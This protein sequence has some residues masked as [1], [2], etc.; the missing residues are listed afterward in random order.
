MKI[1]WKSAITSAALSVLFVLVY[2]S[3]NW[4]TSLRS[5]IGSCYF[6]WERHIP[7]VPALILPYMSIDLFF[8]AAPFLVRSDRELSTLARRITAAILISGLCFLL[9]PLKFAFERP[10]LD[11]FLGV[12]FNNFRTMDL[13]YNEFPSLH[14]SLWAILLDHYRRHTKGLLWI[15]VAVWFTLISI[16]PLFTYQHHVVDI[17]GGLALA[18][19]CFHFFRDQLLCQ[20]FTPNR[21]VAFYYA[22]ACLLLTAASFT[23]APWTY[24]L[25]WPAFSL[26]L[27]VAAYAFIGP[28]LYRKEQGR[29]PWTTWL[30][31]W[32]IL[33]GQR[34]S[35]IFYSRQC[36]PYDRLTDHLWIGR[37]LSTREARQA[38]TSGVTAVVDLTAEFTESAPFRSLPYLQLPILDLTP[39]TPRQ[40]DQA[41]D[42]ITR[43]SGQGVVY[44]HCKVGYSRTAA[45]AGAYM[46]AA[47]Q[48]DTVEQ[49]LAMVRRVR[50]TI[51]V[52]QEATTAL[53]MYQTQRPADP[54][55]LR[56]L[57]E[58]VD[59]NPPN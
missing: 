51:T 16:S 29:L 1:F 28:G 30:L 48:V 10:A 33:L 8:V 54:G 6:L 20:P 50:P 55:E 32:P 35:L 46:L 36:Q 41:V 7:F 23:W 56:R 45:I 11:G 26:T 37:H 47:G 2:S 12:I 43:H 19:L 39:P 44:L 52:R 22:A 57:S 24:L 38:C 13:P 31:L 42:F 18:I 34:L 59:T 3:C 21:R 14:V 9:F 17:L 53:Q 58:A 15:L 27:V 40:I 4:I 49:A 5:H 25:W